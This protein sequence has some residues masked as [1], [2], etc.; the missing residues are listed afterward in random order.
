MP[1]SSKHEQE[2]Y[3][4]ILRCQTSAEMEA[5][6]D[7]LLTPQERHAIAERLQII[8]G[9]VQGRT[10]RELAEALGTSIATVTRGSRVVQFGKVPWQKLLRMKKG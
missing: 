1:A 7:D 10:Q 3:Q 8:R 4:L 5:L 9:L 6:F 2:L